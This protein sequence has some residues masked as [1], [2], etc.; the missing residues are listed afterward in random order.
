[1]YSA[2]NGN[3]SAISI[4]QKQKAKKLFRCLMCVACG[5]LCSQVSNENHL[6][7]L[8]TDA[9]ENAVIAKQAEQFKSGRIPY[10]TRWKFIG[11]SKTFQNVIEWMAAL[12]NT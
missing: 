3:S 4:K 12:G 8:A 1:M 9:Q 7:R 5:E 6:F 11:E 10:Y 2:L